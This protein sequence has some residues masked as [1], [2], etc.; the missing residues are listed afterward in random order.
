MPTHVQ[1]AAYDKA[2]VLAEAGQ[3]QE[4]F[5]Q[6][7]HYL[8]ESPDDAEALNELKEAA[9]LDPQAS[10]THLLLARLYERGGQKEEAIREAELALAAPKPVDAHLLL[11]K[12]YLEQNKLQEAQRH[13]QQVLSMEPGNVAAR[14]VLQTIQMRS[15]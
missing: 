8:R 10:D 7:Q 14:S 12:V 11:A 5:D 9:T 6:I 15:P 13:A 4:A 2:V 3:Y 1:T